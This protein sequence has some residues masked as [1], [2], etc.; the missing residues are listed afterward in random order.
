MESQLIGLGSIVLIALLV[1]GLI[2]IVVG[3]L[4]TYKAVQNQK[5]LR[6]NENAQNQDVH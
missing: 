4:L 6:E 2:I 1:I 5:H 3:G